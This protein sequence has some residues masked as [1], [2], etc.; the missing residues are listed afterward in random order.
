MR[1]QKTGT[2][3]PQ[4]R[5]RVLAVSLD[6]HLGSGYAI[7]EKGDSVLVAF[8]SGRREWI[9]KALLQ[10][11]TMDAV[12][13]FTKAVQDYTASV[14][15]LNPAEQV[16]LPSTLKGALTYADARFAEH[17]YLSAAVA[18]NV[19]VGPMLAYTIATAR[20]E[21]PE[22][23]WSPAKGVLCLV[24]GVATKKFIL[25]DDLSREFGCIGYIT[26]LRGKKVYAVPVFPVILMSETEVL[27]AARTIR[28]SEDD[29]IPVPLEMYAAV[30]I[31]S[32]KKTVREESVRTVETVLQEVIVT[33]LDGFYDIVESTYY[34]RLVA[35]LYSISEDPINS[36][37]RSVCQA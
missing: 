31:Q 21:R 20:G 30:L 9:S 35:I 22:R 13:S 23:C 17:P 7:R 11:A 32:W 34:E 12:E 25:A 16:T 26:N 29:F 37:L 3:S 27:K 8:D 18:C 33:A 14:R 5:R 4:V 19:A 36:V 28:F 6:G 15:S 24:T 1:L 2:L 10:T